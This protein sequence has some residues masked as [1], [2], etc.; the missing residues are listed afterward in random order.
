M[1]YELIYLEPTTCLFVLYVN[2]H[3]IK[4]PMQAL[5][6]IE[7]HNQGLLVWFLVRNRLNIY[8][9]VCL[10]AWLLAWVRHTFKTFWSEQVYS[11]NLYWGLF[12]KANQTVHRARNILEY[13]RRSWWYSTYCTSILEEWPRRFWKVDPF[14]NKNKFNWRR[15]SV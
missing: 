13:S 15:H 11:L 5:N 14:S 9:C 10:L 2:K 1:E 4:C 7:F 6:C 3:D 8:C 12:E